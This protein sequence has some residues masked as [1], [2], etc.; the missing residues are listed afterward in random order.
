MTGVESDIGSVTDQKKNK[1]RTWSQ[2]VS[3]K[4]EQKT[5]SA[6]I[7]RLKQSNP[8]PLT[9][10]ALEL[11]NQALLYVVDKCVNGISK[12]MSHSIGNALTPMDQVAYMEY[13]RY[14]PNLMQAKANQMVQ[15]ILSKTLVRGRAI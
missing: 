4:A 1:S 6:L 9:L 5:K 8:L 12:A 11:L 13:I 7:A 15:S 14:I 3:L 2:L 10:P